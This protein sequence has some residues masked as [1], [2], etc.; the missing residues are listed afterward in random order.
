MWEEYRGKKAKTKMASLPCGNCLAS[1]HPPL[2]IVQDENLFSEAGG[3]CPSIPGGVNV[4]MGVIRQQWCVLASRTDRQATKAV[5]PASYAHSLHS[6]SVCKS[7]RWI[8]F[9]SPPILWLSFGVEC[10]CSEFLILLKDT[11]LLLIEHR[12][13]YLITVFF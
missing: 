1:L 3:R 4:T 8:S 9:S 13:L 6:D 10:W 5:V 7:Q 11:N 2:L 12:F